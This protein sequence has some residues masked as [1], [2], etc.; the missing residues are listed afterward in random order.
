MPV[1]RAY[2]LPARYDGGRTE[3]WEGSCTIWWLM[4]GGTYPPPWLGI[5]TRTRKFVIC[6]A[7]Q[8]QA[9][10]GLK[11]LASGHSEEGSILGLGNLVHPS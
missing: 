8:S 5:K 11:C 6:W 10:D 3:G 7:L 4:M 9:I 1:R 2:D